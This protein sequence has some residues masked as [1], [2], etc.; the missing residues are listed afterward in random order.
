MPP[1]SYY[2]L[3]ESEKAA[4][5]AYLQTYKEYKKHLLRDSTFEDWKKPFIMCAYEHGRISRQFHRE[6]EIRWLA[7]PE[8][9]A[10]E[11][12]KENITPVSKCYMAAYCLI[13]DRG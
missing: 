7:V 8:Q 4:V 2:S 10:D 9:I 11:L 6:L 1:Q 13:Q 3:T 5:D 12:I